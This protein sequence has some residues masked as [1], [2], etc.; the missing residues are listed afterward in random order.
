M[1]G[2]PLL[3]VKDLKVSYGYITAVQGVNLQVRRGEVVTLI[4]A[5]GAGKTTVLKAIAGLLAPQAGRV[6][7]E[8]NPVTGRPSHELARRGLAVVPEGRQVFT[9][10]TV[11]ENLAL[12]SY[13]VADP[14][15]VRQTREEILERFPILRQRYRQLAGTLSGGEQQMLAIGRALMM[16]PKVILMDEPSMGLAP[17]VVQL[18]YDFIRQVIHQGITILLIEQNARMALGVAERGYVLENGRVVLEAPAGDLARDPMVK[19]AYLGG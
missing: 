1:S 17:K 15:A 3:E 10:L 13:T 6:T 14:I 2:E 12:G 11:G 19:A 8:G 18:V 7:L 4:G 9:E 16:R 5:N